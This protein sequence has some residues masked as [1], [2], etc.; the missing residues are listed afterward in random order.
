[1][2]IKKIHAREILDSRALP[3]VE[4]DLYTEKGLFRAAVPSGA[5][6][7]IYEALELRDGGKR[8]NG[9]SVQTAVRN[10]NDK[11]APKLLG[12][13]V[14]DQ[15]GIDKIM[16]DLDGTDK[17]K[18]LGAN[19][20]LAVSMAVARAAAAEKGL[21]LYRYLAQLAG[22]K[23]LRLP[24]PCLNVINGGKHAGNTLP[25]QEFM[26]A[27]AGAS[28]FE[29]AIRM[30]A[31]IYNIL[32]GIIKAKF[33]IDA[34]NV[35]DEGGFAPPVL[36]IFEPLEILVEA[37]EK[38]GYTGKVRIC[39]DSAASEFHDDKDNTYN[40]GFKAKTPEKIT[41]EEFQHKYLQMAEKYPIASFEDPFD[42]DDF[43]SY[44]KLT[45]ALKAKGVQVVGDDLL[46]TNV[47][48]IKM[49]L[50]KKACNSLLLK[51][52]QIGTV[53][54][55]IDAALLALKNGWSVMVS[56]RSG[57]TEDTFIADLAVGI[58]CGQL[59][60]GAPCRG[61]RTAK[62]NQLLRIEEELGKEAKYGYDK[63]KK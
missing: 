60:T 53:T 11:I 21:P 8:F 26:I 46:V 27:P 29:E 41:G 63:W 50:E 62:Y 40:L 42:Q 14:L 39:L 54:E 22:N 45:E 56:H 13:S 31:E 52:N 58:G 17:K 30:G 57:E 51:V 33:G 4:C 12:K 18:N 32:K 16:I 1:M 44:G 49:A 28:T 25:I 23:E 5:S 35:G 47:E 36:D 55:A 48:R 43:A 9:K 38:A 3:T 24:V 20:I 37:I 10:V 2:A 59:K 34:T 6:T 15:R 61:E 7:G 19:A